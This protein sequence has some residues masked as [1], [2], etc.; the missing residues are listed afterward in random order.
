MDFSQRL[1][2]ITLLKT[3][4]AQGAEKAK[5]KGKVRAA[6]IQLL[7]ERFDIGLFSDLSVK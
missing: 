4:S 7:V 3:G 6:A 5:G 1:L 2:D